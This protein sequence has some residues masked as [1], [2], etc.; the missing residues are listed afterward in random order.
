[1]RA[2]HRIRVIIQKPKRGSAGDE[3]FISTF[4]FP[5]KLA[6]GIEKRALAHGLSLSAIINQVLDAYVK[7][8]PT[9]SGIRPLRTA[10]PTPWGNPEAKPKKRAAAGVL[11]KLK[12]RAA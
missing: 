11:S 6:Q 2:D 10:N 12:A 7:Q 4:R 8:T 3:F 5:L 9:P 1:M